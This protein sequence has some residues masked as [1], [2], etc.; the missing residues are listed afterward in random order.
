MM[1]IDFSASAKRDFRQRFRQ[2][3]NGVIFS[4]LPGG[5]GRLVSNREA[6]TYIAEFDAVI[7][8]T[9]KRRR[10]IVQWV[11][12]ALLFHVLG[13]ALR[14]IPLIVITVWIVYALVATLIVTVFQRMRAKRT[15]WHRVERRVAIP[16]LSEEEKI[17]RGFKI[18]FKDWLWIIPVAILAEA[19]RIPARHFE[20]MF[21]TGPLATAHHWFQAVVL[22]TGAIILVPVGLFIGALRIR[23]WWRTR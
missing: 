11:I 21:G 5:E 1:S 4:L 9:A 17:K 2:S 15:A 13:Y 19:L 22:T 23:H 10:K 20:E 3:P 12:L 18:G 8:R 6:E 16:S 14:S 7:D